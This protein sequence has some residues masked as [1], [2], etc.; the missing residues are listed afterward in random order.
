MDPPPPS[1][2]D[3]LAARAVQRRVLA[4]EIVVA[5]D[6]STRLA[7]ELHVLRLAAQCRMLVDAVT[8]AERGELLNDRVRAYLAPRADNYIILD[9]GIRADAHVGHDFGTLTNYG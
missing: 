1:G 2:H 4:Y 9:D 5:D 7:P 6:E 3:A 8:L